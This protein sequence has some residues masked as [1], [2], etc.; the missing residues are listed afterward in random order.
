MEQLTPWCL[1]SAVVRRSYVYPIE[2]NVCGVFMEC[3]VT[4]FCEHWSV[5]EEVQTLS[6]ISFLIWGSP[7]LSVISFTSNITAELMV[8]LALSIHLDFT[9]IQ[10]PI[11]VI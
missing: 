9:L 5:S 4:G 7:I 8:A 1:D 2:G 6:E 11:D 3:G 10:L